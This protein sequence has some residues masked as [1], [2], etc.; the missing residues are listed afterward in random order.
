MIIIHKGTHMKEKE[1]VPKFIEI[2]EAKIG[3]S[4]IEQDD[5][6]SKGHGK[7]KISYIFD[8]GYFLVNFPTR[9]NLIMFAPKGVRWDK[10]G[11]SGAK[12]IRLIDV[13][14]EIVKKETETIKEKKEIPVAGSQGTLF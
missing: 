10:E 12:R 7:G 11:K 9:E 4:V 6:S 2:T 1:S 3:D 5:K 13:S 14:D 8:R